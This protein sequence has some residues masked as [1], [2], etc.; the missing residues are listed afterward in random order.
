VALHSAC[1]IFAD[2]FISFFC[3]LLPLPRV[4]HSPT[5][6]SFASY[7]NHTSC[8]QPLVSFTI[9][10][11]HLPL[12]LCVPSLRFSS[13]VPTFLPIF[14][15]AVSTARYPIAQSNLIPYIDVLSTSI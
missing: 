5:C 11:I 9:P 1:A 4:L 6:I 15:R 2:S 10:F 13:S 14:L 7:F 3:L 12:T 8:L